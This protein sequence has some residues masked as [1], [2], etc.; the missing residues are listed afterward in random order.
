MSAARDLL[1]IAT[2]AR[3][4][5]GRQHPLVGTNSPEP[6]C[7]VLLA[8]ELAGND[9]R[10]TILGSPRHSYL[11]DDLAELF[12]SAARGVFD[13]FF[14]G[15]GQIDGQAN[16]NLVGIGPYPAL[17]KRWP[18]SHGTPLLYMM[19]P[20]A[21]IYVRAEHTRKTLVPKV[22]FISTAGVSD[23]RVHRPGGPVA[24]VTS[25]CVFRFDRARGRFALASLH[26]G[27]SVEDL[28][29]N[30]GFDFDVD[31][32]LGETPGP[33]RQ[34]LEVLRDKVCPDISHLYP[35]FAARIGHEADR[36]LRTAQSLPAS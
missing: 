23:A 16:V 24:M 32:L 25:R 11:S 7:A 35:Q 30:T 2:F 31:A 26:P 12:D 27:E 13:A 8:R 34:M 3:L 1:F 14:I 29:S 19:I 4:L 10:V 21:I 15:G 9:M 5:A 22:D 33:T 6:A 36:Q 28:R 17:E 18:G 20:N